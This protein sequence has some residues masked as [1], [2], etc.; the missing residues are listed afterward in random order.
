[1]TSTPA[2]LLIAPPFPGYRN[3]AECTQ[4]SKHTKAPEGYIDWHLWAEKKARSHVQHECPTC[5]FWAIW[6]PK[7]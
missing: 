7:R 3:A 6:K 2:E 1:V 5:G 4:A